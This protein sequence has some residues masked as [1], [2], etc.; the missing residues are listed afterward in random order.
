MYYCQ[1]CFNFYITVYDYLLIFNFIFISKSLRFMLIF[2]FVSF[3]FITYLLSLKSSFIY[4]VLKSSY[5]IQEP[6]I[7]FQLLYFFTV[8]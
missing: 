4:L 3:I 6:T 2:I 1:L 8:S 5:F 7:Y